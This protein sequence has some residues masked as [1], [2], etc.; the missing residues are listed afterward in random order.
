MQWVG[1]R[2]PNRIIRWVHMLLLAALAGA[3]LP[4]QPAA[5]AAAATAPDQLGAALRAAS[6]SPALTNGI[7]LTSDILGTPSA[8]FNALAASPAADISIARM[9]A[10]RSV[11]ELNGDVLGVVLRVTN[12][13]PPAARDLLPLQTSPTLSS[14]AALEHN[15][16]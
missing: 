4:R 1:I 7:D 10:A 12:H 9:P 13:Q 6:P 14:T 5:T 2:R 3:L 8:A 16:R 15:R 11:A